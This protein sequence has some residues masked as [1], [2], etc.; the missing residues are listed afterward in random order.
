MPVLAGPCAGL[1]AA[2]SSA[3]I[4]SAATASTAVATVP[5]AGGSVELP[6]ASDEDEEENQSPRLQP[7]PPEE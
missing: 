6:E 4:A 2:A 7:D 5:A 1:I 3:A